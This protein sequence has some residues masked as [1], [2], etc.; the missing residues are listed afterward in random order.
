MEEKCV[1][2]MNGIVEQMKN[3]KVHHKRKEN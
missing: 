1:E 2:Q 3:E